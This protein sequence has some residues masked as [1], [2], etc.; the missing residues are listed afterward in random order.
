MKMR[1][2]TEQSEASLIL[3]SVKPEFK[4]GG[5]LQARTFLAPFG[6]EEI[7]VVHGGEED[8][9]AGTPIIPKFP[10]GADNEKQGPSSSKKDMSEG[11]DGQGGSR[12]AEEPMQQDATQAGGEDDRAS[13]G[14][15]SSLDFNFLNDLENNADTSEATEP[16]DQGT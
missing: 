5:T 13:T 15:I 9:S 6:C 16:A 2:R 4:E 7:K 12:Q 3:T 11:D 14:G 10:E 1:G 8:G